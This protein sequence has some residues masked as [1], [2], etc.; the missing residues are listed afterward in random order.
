MVF[1]MRKETET[2]EAKLRNQLTPIYGLDDLILMLDT[3]PELM[4]IIVEMAKQ[5]VKNKPK[6]KSL[7]KKIENEKK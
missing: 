2:S 3:H 6:I 1:I 5:V 7:L 4:P